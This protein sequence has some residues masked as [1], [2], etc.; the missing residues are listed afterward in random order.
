MH[1]HATD[2]RLTRLG[3]R[4]TLLASGSADRTIRLWSLPSGRPLR[5]LRGHA[6][7]V[8]ALAID[9]AGRTL[10]SAGYDRT[11]RLWSLAPVV[12]SSVTL[13]VTTSPSAP[14]WVW[15]SGLS[16]ACGSSSLIA[17]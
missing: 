3:H 13:C 14:W 6:S 8:L 2:I 17:P 9:P 10:V 5:I 7:G 16:K 15:V 1:R 11:V 12:F 4:G